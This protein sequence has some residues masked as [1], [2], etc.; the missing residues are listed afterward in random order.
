[1]NGTS[2]YVS[3]SPSSFEYCPLHRCDT[4]L[5]IKCQT[6]L[7]YYFNMVKGRSPYKYVNMNKLIGLLHFHFHS[8]SNST[9]VCIQYVIHIVIILLFV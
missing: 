1:M 2:C 9:K 6:F 8:Y 5:K 4:T 3:S 7:N